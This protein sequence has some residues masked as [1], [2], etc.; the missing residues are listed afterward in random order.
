MRRGARRH[1]VVLTLL[2][3]AACGGA[4]EPET[5]PPDLA[6]GQ[7]VCARCGMS[8]DDPRFAAALREGAEQGSSSL[9]VYDDV[10]EIFLDM[11]AP[12]GIAPSEIWVHDAESSA[13]IEGRSAHYVRGRIA[14]PMALGIEAYAG[15][16]AATRRAG[17][18]GGEVLGFDALMDLARR[19]DLE[20]NFNQEDAR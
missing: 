19:G 10:G 13:W 11:A 14:S 9:F 8:V 12:Q 16:E 1:V 2:F 18:I 17:E 3:L 15:A 7:R 6:F 20:T 4:V 5:G